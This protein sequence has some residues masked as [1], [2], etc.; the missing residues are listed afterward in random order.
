MRIVKRDHTAYRARIGISVALSSVAR[1]VDER[2][3]ATAFLYD[4]LND[5]PDNVE[6]EIQLG[7]ILSSFKRYSEALPL[8]EKSWT[9]YQNVYVGRQYAKSLFELGRVETVPQF[10]PAYL[11]LLRNE[12]T[13]TKRY[14]FP[15]IP[16]LLIFLVIPPVIV[17]SDKFLTI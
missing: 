10:L 5:D 11:K 16:K 9:T 12:T 4:V 3:K 7:M 2:E 13:A 17:N 8:L 14:A 15:I 1:S 6:A